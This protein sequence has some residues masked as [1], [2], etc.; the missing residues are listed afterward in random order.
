ME[1][2]DWLINSYNIR[3]NRVPQLTKNLNVVRDGPL[4]LAGSFQVLERGRYTKQALLIKTCKQFYVY[5]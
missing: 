1:H 4:I 2:S 3:N 5:Y